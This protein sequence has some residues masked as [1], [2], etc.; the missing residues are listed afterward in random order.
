MITYWPNNRLI[1]ESYTKHMIKISKNIIIVKEDC[2][3]Y[4][5]KKL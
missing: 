1:L 3:T 2:K 5:S 4:S